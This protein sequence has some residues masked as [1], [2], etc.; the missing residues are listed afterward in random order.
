LLLVTLAAFSESLPPIL[1]NQNHVL[2]GTLRG[3]ILT[4]HLEIAKG[5]WH[6][7][8]EDGVALSVYAFGESG[9][10]LQ[11]PGPLIR[12]PQGTEIQ[13]WLHNALPISVAVHGLGERTGDSD[14]VVRV[15]PGTVEQVHFTTKTPGLYLYWA[16]TD[17][18]ILSCA[19][20]S[21]RS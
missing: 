21:M 6:P 14:A 9:K 11:N 17:V 12:V 18:M 2:A 13:A 10:S 16:A 8:A 4:I 19:M 5:V 20:V 15:A 1:A 7:E 3:G